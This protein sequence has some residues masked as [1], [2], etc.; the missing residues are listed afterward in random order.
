MKRGRIIWCAALVILLGASG[1]G[2]LVFR[3]KATTGGPTLSVQFHPFNPWR[4]GHR[5]VELCQSAQP[6]MVGWIMSV[7]PISVSRLGHWQPAMM[8]ITNGVIV[9]GTNALAGAG[10]K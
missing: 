4:F 9:G 6:M 7:G 2:V 5:R 10:V 3:A 1:V 8:G